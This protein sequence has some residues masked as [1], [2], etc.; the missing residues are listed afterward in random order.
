MPD[1]AHSSRLMFFGDS[2]LADGF[3][4]IGFETWC[5][6][7]EDTLEQQM[8]RLRDEHGS[9]LVL[10]DPRCAVLP[11]P[12]LQALRREGGRVIIS[13]VP[14]INAPAGEADE[15]DRRIAQLYHASG[16]REETEGVES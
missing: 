1:N 3:R 16:A 12:S 14:A 9:A 6:V 15:L 7:D 8:R 13:Q 5:D 11:S 4:L 2:T 10:L